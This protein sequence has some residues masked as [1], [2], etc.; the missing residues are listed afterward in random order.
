MGFEHE[1]IHIETSSVLIR[2]VRAAAARG[3]DGGRRSDG[4]EEWK[5]GEGR[6]DQRE[7][8]KESGWCG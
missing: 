7:T 1:R 3:R 5:G 8:E 2:E 4:R 6:K